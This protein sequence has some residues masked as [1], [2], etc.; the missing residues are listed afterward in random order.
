MDYTTLANVKLALGSEASG[1]DTSLA[2]FITR[3]SRAMDT[4]CAG[5]D[6][7][8][9]FTRETI[10]DELLRGQVD[11]VGCIQCWPHK[12]LIRS[13]TALSYRHSPLESW[14]AAPVE[15]I[16]H[17]GHQVS[18]WVSLGARGTIKVKISYDGG[19]SATPDGLPD[20]LVE[21]ATMLSIRFFKEGKSG[22]NDMIGIADMEGTFMYTKALPVRFVELMKKY[23]RVVPW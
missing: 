21:L 10:A 18:G 19:L 20:D 6:A 13:V 15:H 14:Q 22:L 9:Y 3:A 16:D 1:A 11:A 17:D 7:A 4:Y 2:K 5:T 12:G 8:N 23:R